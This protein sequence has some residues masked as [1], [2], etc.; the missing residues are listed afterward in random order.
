[1]KTVLITGAY[2]FVGSN[3]A[4]MF[5]NE[6]YRTIGIGRGCFKSNEQ[7]LC[8]IDK[9]IEGNVQSDTLSLVDSNISLVVHCA[10]CSSVQ[11]AIENPIAEFNSTVGS[12]ISL[13]EYIKTHQSTAK[14]IYISSAAVYG[15]CK[16]TMIDEAS[17]ISPV[18][19]Y[20]LYKSNVEDIL[21]FYSHKFC[22][23]VTV[24]RFFSIYGVGLKKQLIWDAC[25]KFYEG[26]SNISFHGTGN[27]TRDWINIKDAVD[28]I[29]F[30]SK[31][32]GGYK[33]YN[34]GSGKRL[35]ISH[36]LKMISQKF[37][38]LEFNMTALTREG[39]PEHYWANIQRLEKL[40]WQTSISFEKGLNEYL[41]WYCLMKS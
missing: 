15:K 3:T 16:D 25:N 13:I 30:V 19:V 20:G 12:T 24:I 14:I 4:K 21:K 10:G 40:G 1:M 27:E 33:I 22:I 6:G 29:L 2:G 38:N 26:H 32:M 41:N 37:G 9:W 28:L 5:K 8:G 34:G 11:K 7:R 18:S 39:D 23:P 35:K 36:V 17:D 31:H